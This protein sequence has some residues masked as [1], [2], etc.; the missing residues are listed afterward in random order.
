[1]RRLILALVVGLALVVVLYLVVRPGD[2]TSVARPGL[3]PD[4][5]LTPGAVIPGVTAEQVCRPGYASSARN[6]TEAEKRQVFE[7]YHYTGP[8]S[9]VEV[10]HLISLELGG[11]NDVTNLWPEPYEPRP[12]AHEKDRVE[13][14][15]HAQVCAG[16]MTLQQTQEAI[17]KDWYAVYKQIAK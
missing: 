7:R 14:H 15:L 2:S 16:R 12:G 11:S 3:Y 6:V 17:R 1:M 9:A 13:D 4:P 5:R 10:D 8:H